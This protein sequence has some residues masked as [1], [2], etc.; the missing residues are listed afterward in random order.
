MADT[1]HCVCIYTDTM[2][3]LTDMGWLILDSSEPERET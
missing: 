1:G 2:T 3:S